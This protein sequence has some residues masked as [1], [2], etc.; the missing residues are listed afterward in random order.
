MVWPAPWAV[1]SLAFLAPGDDPI[2]VVVSERPSLA[3]LAHFPR[4]AEIAGVNYSDLLRRVSVLVEARTVLRVDEVSP[5]RVDRCV[6]PR[7]SR[8][9]LGLVACLTAAVFPAYAPG[10]ATYA[11]WTSDELWLRLEEGARRLPRHALF[12]TASQTETRGQMY[13]LL[14]DTRA[15]VG[16]IHSFF[17]SNPNPRE[18]DYQRLEDGL[19]EVVARSRRTPVERPEDVDA[20]FERLFAAHFR[21]AL[22]RTGA[23]VRFGVIE[24]RGDD[25]AEVLLDGVRV[26]ETPG[27]RMRLLGVLPGRHTVRIYRADSFAFEREV[28]VTEGETVTESYA[29][30]RNAPIRRARIGILT[31]GAVVA[32]T[33]FT[34]VA[35][36]I[37]SARVRSEARF[38]WVPQGQAGFGLDFARWGSVPIAPL[39]YGLVAFG[40]GGVLGY[41]LTDADEVPWGWAVAGVLVGAAAFGV[42][43]AVDDAAGPN[44]PDL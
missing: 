41:L 1:A 22:S 4:R 21:D 23:F 27:G 40:A 20:F 18:V 10:D 15:A 9:R 42:S 36:G 30:V 26:A 2:T 19:T 3:L 43:V 32:A 38:D 39:G 5:A 14:V 37:S 29:L 44:R 6:S 33:G 7:A 16:R 28:V 17:Q 31:A 8:R 12:V 35:V 24:L 25:P 11:G 34:L 13:A